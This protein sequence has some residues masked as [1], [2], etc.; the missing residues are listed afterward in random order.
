MHFKKSIH[1]INAQNM[2]HI[3]KLTR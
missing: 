1:P 2:E 3:K